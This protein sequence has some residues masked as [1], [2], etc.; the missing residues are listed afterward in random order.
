MRHRQ[1]IQ[2][3]ARAVHTAGGARMHRQW[4]RPV[5]LLVVTVPVAFPVLPAHQ[6]HG[7]SALACDH[8]TK[9]V[10]I[11]PRYVTRARGGAQ[12]TL[13]CRRPQQAR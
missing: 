11:Q 7:L 8:N 12:G 2:A 1:H 4:R 6:I 3:N 13:T 5:R 10:S 9:P